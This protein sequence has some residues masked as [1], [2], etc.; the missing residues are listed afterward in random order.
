MLPK[1]RGGAAPFQERFSGRLEK[2]LAFR[3]GF[4]LD[5]HLICSVYGFLWSN[6]WR[7]QVTDVMSL[8]EELERNAQNAPSKTGWDAPAQQCRVSYLGEPRQ[9]T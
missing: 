7:I 5:N 4:E 1:K 6:G 9:V 3:L 8:D 2:V